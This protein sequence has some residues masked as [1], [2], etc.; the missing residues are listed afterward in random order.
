[1]K[2]TSHVDE[3]VLVHIIIPAANVI[4]EGWYSYSLKCQRSL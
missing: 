4:D 2:V 3:V 1:M